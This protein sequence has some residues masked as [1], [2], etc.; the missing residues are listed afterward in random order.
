MQRTG[1]RR[2]FRQRQVDCKC[3]HPSICHYTKEG[4]CV[5]QAC[6][7]KKYESAGRQLFPNQRSRCQ[8]GHSHDSGLEIKVCADLHYE[9]LANKIRSF[10]AQKVLE[11]TGPSGATVAHYKVDFVVNHLDGSTEFVE[12]KGDHIARLGAWPVKWALLQDMHTGD[13]MFKFRVVRG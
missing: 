6:E 10:D 4:H 8:Y 2:S 13:P 11:L 1:F 12:C 9:R 7:C 5:Y 3:G